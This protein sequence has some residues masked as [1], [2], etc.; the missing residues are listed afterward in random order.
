LRRNGWRI[1]R[2][3]ND[4]VFHRL[5]A[6]LESIWNALPPPSPAVTPPPQAGEDK[7]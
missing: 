5:D 2:F 7:K 6:V 4:D 3:Q 1:V